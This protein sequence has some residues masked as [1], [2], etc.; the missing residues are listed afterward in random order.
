MQSLTINLCFFKE[1]DWVDS[2]RSKLIQSVTLVMPIADEMRQ[3]KM[4][5]KETYNKI[6]AATTSQDKMREFYNALTT[7]EVKSAFF[8]SLQEIQPE[9]CESM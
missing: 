8:R 6:D 4:I 3:Q 2:N 5:H 1:A 9:T 7:Q